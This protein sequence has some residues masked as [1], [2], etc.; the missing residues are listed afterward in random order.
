MSEGALNVLQIPHVTTCWQTFLGLSEGEFLAR[1][2]GIFH[3]LIPGACKEDEAV[4][5]HFHFAFSDSLT[6]FL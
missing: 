2:P 1:V 5:L 6:V 4:S 3:C